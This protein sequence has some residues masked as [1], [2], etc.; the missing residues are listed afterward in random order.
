MRIVVAAAVRVAGT[1]ARDAVDP[2]AHQ[3]RVA[4]FDLDHQLTVAGERAETKE[5][6]EKTFRLH[7]RLERAF[8]RRF[9]LPT[10]ADTDHVE[11]TFAN[12]VLVLHT[13]KLAVSKPTTIEIG[14]K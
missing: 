8:E 14:K 3:R 6:T 11:A 12:G 10:E 13:P 2:L 1:G 7:E 9:Y 4:F 5:Q